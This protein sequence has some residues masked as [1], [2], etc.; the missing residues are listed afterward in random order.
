MDVGTNR[1]SIMA[2]K[3]TN[4]EI[5]LRIATIYEMVVKGCSRKMIVRYGSETWNISSRQI[6]DYLKIVYE[7]IKSTYGQDYKEKLIEKQLAQL[8][9][10]YVKNYTIEDF[11]ECRNLIETKSK[12]LGLNEPDKQSISLNNYNG[13]NGCRTWSSQ[14][15]IQPWS[16]HSSTKLDNRRQK[17][18]L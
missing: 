2:E 1:F 8:D 13:S 11:R 12:L 15:I 3:S 9:D 10:L 16:F 18:H 6:D 5:E 14:N 17:T 4:A 7:E